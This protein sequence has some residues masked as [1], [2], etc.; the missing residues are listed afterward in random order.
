MRASPLLLVGRVVRHMNCSSYR[1]KI[2][3][4]FLTVLSREEYVELVAGVP[5]VSV[6]YKYFHWRTVTVGYDHKIN[7]FFPVLCRSLRSKILEL[8]VSKL[9]AL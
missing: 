1:H 3:A 6:P 7:I 4:F 2:C 9:Y 5:V 8:Q